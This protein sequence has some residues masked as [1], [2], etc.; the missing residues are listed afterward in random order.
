MDYAPLR[1]SRPAP[2]RLA[3]QSRRKPGFMQS[4]LLWKGAENSRLRRYSLFFGLPIACLWML[5]GAYVMLTPKTYV[6]EMTLNLPGAASSS[7][8]SVDSIGQAS[9]TNGNP[10]NSAAMSPKVIYK[11]I[12]ESARV[13]GMAAKLLGRTGMVGKPVIK[14]IDETAIMQF[15]ISATSPEGAQ[16]ESKALLQALQT[17]LDT[18]RNDEVERRS[19]AVERGLKD[20]SRNLAM[21]REK[22]LAYQGTSEVLSPEQYRAQVSSVENLRQKLADVQANHDR[23]AAEAESLGEMLGIGAREATLALKVQADPR[24]AAANTELAAAMAEESANR[25]KWADRHPKVIAAAARTAAARKAIR[26]AAARQGGKA[27][28]RIVDHLILGDSRDRAELFRRLVEAEAARSGLA[29]E[30]TSLQATLDRSEGKLRNQAA[31]AAKLEDLDRDHKIAEAVF[32]SALARVDTNRQ[33]IY[34]SYPLL[35]VMS[36]ASLP[37]AASSPKPLIAVAGALIGTLLILGALALAW[38]RQP[39]LQKLLK[40]D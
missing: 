29:S 3:R 37:D 14:L 16:Q 32:S 2:R 12:A 10:F 35:Q 8:I 27:A 19:G 17:Y 20:V 6:S 7:N 4:V 24:F 1:A 33:D 36:E 25:A 34:A 22:L 31:Q 23:L 26:S 13:R 9:T 38:I 30:I 18:L 28:A 21:A 40:N 5:V 11:S 15:S 39:I